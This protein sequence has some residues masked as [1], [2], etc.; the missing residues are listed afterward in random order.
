VNSAKIANA[1]LVLQPGQTC[2]HDVSSSRTPTQ[3]IL[4]ALAPRATDYSPSSSEAMWEKKLAETYENIMDSANMT[5]FSTLEIP[6][7][8]TGFYECDPKESAKI[9]VKTVTE[10]LRQNRDTKITEVRFNFNLPGNR[11]PDN[12]YVAAFNEVLFTI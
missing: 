5:G 4:K 1:R 12:H 8:G 11:N 2:P 9:A 7:I 10:W 6:Q 3:F